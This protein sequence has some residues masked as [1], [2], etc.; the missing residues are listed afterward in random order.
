LN[1]RESIDTDVRL[2]WKR[3]IE[4]CCQSTSFSGILPR[5]VHILH[6]SDLCEPGRRI[7]STSVDREILLTVESVP[8]TVS[9]L[10]EGGTTM[11]VYA[12]TYF[13]GHIIALLPCFFELAFTNKAEKQVV[14]KTRRKIKA[15]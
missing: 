2:L 6:F 14:L 3:E 13:A 10:R 15:Q 12:G 8:D 11:P 7:A 5:N 4:V 9:Q 1:S